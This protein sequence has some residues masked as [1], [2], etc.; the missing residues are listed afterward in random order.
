MKLLVSL[1]TFNI[2]MFCRMIYFLTT[3]LTATVMISE[4]QEGIWDRS[5]VAGKFI[6]LL[7]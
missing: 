5:L 1:D 6:I 7:L 2:S 4:R 3:G